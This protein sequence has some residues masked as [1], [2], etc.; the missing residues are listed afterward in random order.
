MCILDTGNLHVNKLVDLQ[1]LNKQHPEHE[2][3]V[4][5]AGTS[6]FRIGNLLFPLSW[7][8]ELSLDNAARFTEDPSA[9]KSFQSHVI[10]ILL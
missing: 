4:R 5:T 1:T 9:C 6:H 10:V 8:R 7:I 2:V 3:K